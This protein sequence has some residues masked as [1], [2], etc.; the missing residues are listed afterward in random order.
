MGELLFNGYKVL[1]QDVENVL[2]MDGGDSC[3]IMSMYLI[4]L[5]TFKMV[6][7]MWYISY[8]N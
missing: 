4:S 6:N 8:Q 5:K 2:E 1:V 7:F 3:T